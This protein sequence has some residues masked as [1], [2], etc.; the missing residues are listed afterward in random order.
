MPKQVKARAAQDEREARAVR[1][2]ARSHH[3][4]ADWMWHARMVVESWAGKT[5]DQIAAELHCHPQTVRIHVARFNQQGIEGLGVQPGSGRKPR[6]TEAE[7]SVI[8]ALPSQPPP[9]RLVTQRDGT[10]VARDERGSAQW[11]LNALAQAA[12][13]AGIK[14]K[15]SQI[16]TILLKEGVRWR[17]THSWGTPRDKDFAPKERRSS[18][19]TPSHPRDRRP[20]A[21]MNSDQ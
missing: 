5:P 3:A 6:L 12:K 19:T 7:R 15:R 21:P 2:L 4:P 11:S 17:Q 8:V 1:K 10:M 13:E 14:V 18:P 16:R 9:G 20:S